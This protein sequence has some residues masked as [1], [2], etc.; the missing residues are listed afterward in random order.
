MVINRLAYGYEPDDDCLCY[1]SIN[2]MPAFRTYGNSYMHHIDH[3]FTYISWL[4]GQTSSTGVMIVIS[5]V[6]KWVNWVNKNLFDR[7]RTKKNWFNEKMIDRST[8]KSNLIKLKS[9]L[10]CLPTIS[11]KSIWNNNKH[12]SKSKVNHPVILRYIDKNGLFPITMWL[13][14]SMDYSCIT[15]SPFVRSLVCLFVLLIK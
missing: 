8:I 9:I 4:Q 10:P 5:N 2:K 3:Q 14:I 12:V 13:P 11:C 7:F 1:K 6:S 15:L